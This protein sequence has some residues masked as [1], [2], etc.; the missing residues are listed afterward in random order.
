MVQQLTLNI[1]CWPNLSVILCFKSLK[2]SQTRRDETLLAMLKE[3]LAMVDDQ[4]PGNQRLY[5]FPCL[6][7]FSGASAT[8]AIA[9]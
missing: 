5:W 8:L 9:A 6:A 2:W 1:I 7:D 4:G 3:E